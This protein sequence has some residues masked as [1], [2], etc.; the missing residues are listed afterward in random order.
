[1]T[2]RA[3]LKSRWYYIG[4]DPNASSTVYSDRSH[5]GHWEEV[6]IT[7]VGEGLY[8][9]FFVAAKVWLSLQPD[10]TFQTRP[11]DSTPGDFETIAGGQIKETGRQILGPFDVERIAA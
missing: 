1:M 5:A 9:V 6:L 2:L 11:G 4:V 10:G 7:R 8:T 3:Y